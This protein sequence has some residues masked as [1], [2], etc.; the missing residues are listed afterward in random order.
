MLAFWFSIFDECS[1]AIFIK[2]SCCWLNLEWWCWTIGWVSYCAL[3]QLCPQMLSRSSW[4]SLVSPWMRKILVRSW[5]PR[6]PRMEQIR[7]NTTMLPSF[8]C[9]VSFLF[10][11]IAAIFGVEVI[12]FAVAGHLMIELSTDIE[13]DCV[14]VLYFPRRKSS[15]LHPRHRLPRLCSK[16]VVIRIQVQRKSQQLLPMC[17]KSLGSMVLTSILPLHI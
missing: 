10:S 6:F 1:V 14:A 9:N 2:M 17:K 7:R 11:P 8:T 3:F 16:T 4:S 15:H 13:T 5:F 12:R